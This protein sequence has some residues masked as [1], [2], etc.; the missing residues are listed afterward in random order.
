MVY[1]TARQV[2]VSYKLQT[3]EGTKP[4]N[5]AAKAF[6]LNEGGLNLTKEPINSNENRRDGMTTRGRHGS[7]NVSGNYSGDLSV[8]TFDEL[9]EAAWWGTF[10]PA[11]TIDEDTAG[12]ASATLAVGANTIT[13]SAGSWITAGLRVGDVIRATAGLDDENLDRNL[14]IIGLTGA[15]ITLAEDLTVEA[16][17]IATYS[18]VRPKKVTQGMTRRAF[19]FEEREI[20][21][22][23]SEVFEWC[24]IGSMA[25]EMQ[26]NGMAT[27]NFSIVGRNMEVLE[28][29]QSPYF[30][31]PS[32]TTSTGLTA[33]EAKI[34]L[35]TTEVVDLTSLSLTFDRRAAGTPVVGSDL[36]PDVF[37]NNMTVAGSITGLR[38]DFSRTKSFL[39]EDTL[40]LHL[41][42][43]EREGEPSEFISLV[44][45]FL[46]LASSSKSAIGQD[47]PRTQTLDLMPG[48]DERG[49][50]Y[51]RC[52]AIWQTSAA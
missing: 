36:T 34:V 35:G 51:E 22:D 16:G 11:L 41:L 21:I 10:S 26:P 28:G 27:V 49:G 30:T 52:M 39:E 20:D 44:I 43:A 46:S 2:E 48:I 12:L 14:R 40:S 19:C 6:R 32:Y 29:A 13:A 8:G 42:F 45:P 18:F 5:S 7:R 15:V 37:D 3:V 4:S 50:A 33:V 25:L 38:K 31:N 9:V 23:G 17:P 24:R 47:G 1:Q